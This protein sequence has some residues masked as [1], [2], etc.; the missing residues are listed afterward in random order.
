MYMSTEAASFLLDNQV[1]F[2]S[3]FKR[4]TKHRKPATKQR[5]E[6]GK[7]WLSHSSLCSLILPTSIRHER[8]KEILW[9]VE[10][11]RLLIALK[12]IIQNTTYLVAAL[13]CTTV[14]E[15]VSCTP[16]L[17]VWLLSSVAKWLFSV[18]LSFSTQPYSYFALNNH[19]KQGHFDLLPQ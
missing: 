6:N 17:H 13:W 8:K 11:L 3:W 4:R 1:M 19:L 7:E 9:Y 10:M 18:E 15:I 2:Q 5:I 12:S 14:G 16:D